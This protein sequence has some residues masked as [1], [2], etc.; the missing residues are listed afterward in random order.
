MRQ[1]FEFKFNFRLVILF[2]NVELNGSTEC[3]LFAIIL[4]APFGISSFWEALDSIFPPKK[5][6]EQLKA[7][8]HNH[9]LFCLLD[10]REKSI[11]VDKYENY[12]M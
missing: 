7:F 9:Q 12:G 4:F 3:D 11:C 10:D 5:A 6:Q 1:A 2:N 8:E